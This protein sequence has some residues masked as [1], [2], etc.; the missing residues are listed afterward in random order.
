MTC[1]VRAKRGEDSLEHRRGHRQYPR[2]NPLHARGLRRTIADI[3]PH[4]LTAAQ[5]DDESLKDAWESAEAEEDG[6]LVQ[7][8]ML[9]H[10]STNAWGEEINQ[11]VLPRKF[12]A[13]VLSLAHCSPLAA[14]LGQRKHAPRS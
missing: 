14:H 4:E 8:G 2:P 10:R 5:L 3:D 13:E 1:S 12:R 6:Y 11:V 7:K 9:Y